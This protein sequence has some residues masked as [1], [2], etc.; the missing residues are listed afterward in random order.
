[1][2]KATRLTLVCHGATS[3]TRT[4]A[5]PLD[6]PVEPSEVQR[7]KD[8]AG[9]LRHAHRF[10]TSP[11]Q[12][13]QQTAQALGLEAAIEAV[14]SDM[15]Y[16]R[17]AGRLL[18]DIHATAP[19]DVENWMSNPAS[20]PHGG[21][22]FNDLLHRVSGWLTTHM[23]D[24]GH[25]IVVTHALVIRAA[26]IHTLQAPVSAFWRIDVEPLSFTELNSDGQR[27]MMRACAN[28]PP[29]SAGSAT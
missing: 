19:G 1:M 12:R 6:E 18:A 11:A 21:E 9:Y 26:I 10:V 15:D 16:G 17:W 20:A 8:I 13:A 24:G 14:I 4:G 27:W 23:D 2:A 5:F 3:A 7:A 29:S 25:T 28:S 22:S